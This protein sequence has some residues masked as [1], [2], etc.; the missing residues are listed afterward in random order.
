MKRSDITA[1]FPNAT[2]EQVKKLMDLNGSD[3]NDAKKGGDEL[4]TQLDKALADLDAAKKASAGAPTPD[5][6]TAAKDA[7]AKLEKELT[8][9]KLANQLRELR[10]TVAKEKGVPAALLTGDTKEACAAQADGIL[11]FSKSQSQQ[12]YPTL[13]DGGD[14]SHHQ[15][16]ST[17]EQFAAW[18]GTALT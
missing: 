17:R 2:E 1:I 12:S 18:A 8:Q 4:R 15:G 13:P 6:L 9:M 10:E 16:A 7:A 3:I 5:E 14:P 11:A